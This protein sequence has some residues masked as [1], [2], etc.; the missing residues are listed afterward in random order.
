MWHREGLNDVTMDWLFL[1]K[2]LPL[3]RVHCSFLDLY[4]VVRQALPTT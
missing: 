1:L 3:A 4:I 2:P